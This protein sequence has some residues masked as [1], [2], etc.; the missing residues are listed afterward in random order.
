MWGKLCRTIKIIVLPDCTKD[1]EC[2]DYQ[3]CRYSVCRNKNDLGDWCEN[4]NEC[5]SNLC[6]E[7]CIKCKEDGDCDESQ[8]CTN[9]SCV[10]KS[11]IVHEKEIENVKITI[12]NTTSAI[13]DIDEP[14]K[15]TE[16]AKK[17]IKPLNVSVSEEVEIGKETAIK[18]TS[19]GNPLEGVKIM[20]DG[21]TYFTDINGTVK[22]KFDTRGSKLIEID[23]DGYEPKSFTINVEKKENVVEKDEKDEK[24]YAGLW[25]LGLLVVI[26]IIIILFM[27]NKNIT[28]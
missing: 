14:K 4:N 22:V 6:A 15:P 12:N 27:K 25:I 26:A 20:V 18:I 11:A 24:D 5:L 2:K 10:E 17:K 13:N 19:N 7:V 21:N 8:E 16:E 3:Y 9:N 1:E 28:K 23:N